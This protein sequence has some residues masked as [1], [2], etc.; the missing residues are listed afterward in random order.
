[1][2]EQE[3]IKHTKK[4]YKI[5]GSKEHSF[6]QKV[7][8]FFVEVFIIVFVITLSIWFHNRSEHSKEQEEV[9]H[10]LLGLKS[11]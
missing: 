8:E 3:V 2:A 9:K 4:V 7:K 1:M 11:D 10:F 5:W 6:R